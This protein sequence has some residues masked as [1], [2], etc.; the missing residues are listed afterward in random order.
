MAN[1]VYPVTVDPG[2]PRLPAVPEGWSTRRLGDVLEVVKRPIEL[3]DD[4]EYTL[5]IAKRGR[6]GIVSRGTRLGKQIRTKTQFEVRAGDFLISRRQIVHGAC[7]LVPPELDGAV[8]SNEYTILRPKADLI[9][10][11]LELLASTPYLQRTFYHSSVG[12]V[13]EKMVFREQEWLRYPVHLPPVTEQQAIAGTAAECRRAVQVADRLMELSS[14][15]KGRVMHY[16]LEERHSRD[17]SGNSSYGA[18]ARLAEVA[19]VRFSGVDK[20]CAEGETPVRLCNYLDVLRNPRIRR[21]L[22]LSGATATHSEIQRFGLRRGDIVLTKDSETAEDIALVA[23][24]EDDFDNVVLGYHLALIRPDLARVDPRFLY[25]ELQ[26]PR[27]RRHFVRHAVGA[28]RSALSLDSVRR[29]EIWLP[30]LADQ[31]IIADVLD[32]L[33]AEG[34]L[35]ERLRAGLDRQRRGV[36]ELLLTGKVRVPA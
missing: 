11:F 28:V 17:R 7:G 35:L 23:R 12:I 15:R 30:K 4:Q 13:V 8:V 25:W 19:D 33:E 18:F 3:V 21:G 10:S 29:A 5:V 14:R 1:R 16:L 27:M 6:G 24:V 20:H 26:S 34:G 31:V 2:I 9:V 22:F 32:L 36:A